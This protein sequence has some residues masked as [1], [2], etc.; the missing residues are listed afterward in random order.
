MPVCAQ[1]RL[2]PF[3][4][5]AFRLQKFLFLHGY[6]VVDINKMIESTPIV[7][8]LKKRGMR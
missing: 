6:H 5:S 8:G 7:Q 2:H 1:T 4:K 3:T